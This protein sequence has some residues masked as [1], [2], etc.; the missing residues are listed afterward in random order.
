MV[1]L[2]LCP[3]SVEKSEHNEMEWNDTAY[4]LKHSMELLPL[5]RCIVECFQ[6]RRH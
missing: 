5:P 1:V 3:C 4:V 2:D 6:K